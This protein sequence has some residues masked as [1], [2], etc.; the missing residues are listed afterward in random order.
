M[1]VLHPI[2]IPNNLPMILS[3]IILTKNEELNLATCLDSLQSLKAPVFIVD[4]GSTD[5]TVAIAKS[6]GC[7]VVEHPFI[8]QAQQLNWALANLKI[9]SDWVMRLDAD[10]RLTP[11]LAAELLTAL[12]DA[13]PQISGYQ[14]K[15]RV[16]FMGKWIR[17]GGYYPIWLL[18]VWRQGKAVCE[19]RCMDEH[20]LLT[21]GSLGSLKFDFIDDNRK[22]LT[23][24]TD[25]HNLYSDREVED[26]LN[27][28]PD[29]L[30]QDSSGKL[31][32]QSRQ[33]RWLKKN[34][35]GN[36]PLF[37][38]PFLYFI[39]RYIFQLGFMDGRTGLVFHFLQGFWY[40]F[41][42]DAKLYQHQIGRQV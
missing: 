32:Q 30:L 35:Y 5:A 34:L 26:L 21:E 18:R 28:A 15:R 11:E 4:S 19:L 33:K 31:Q 29:Q 17:H 25:K 24:W 10:E 27:Q 2:E 23:F 3:F 41:L 20:M 38:R 39:Y 14:A 13:P 7:E 36:L 1:S 42:I 37:T 22:D 8:N 40:R 6:Y 9:D 12:A 16:Y